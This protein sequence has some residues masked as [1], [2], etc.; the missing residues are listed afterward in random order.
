MGQSASSGGSPTEYATR[1]PLL[2][3]LRLRVKRTEQRRLGSTGDL[4]L[5][6]FRTQRRPLIQEFANHPRKIFKNGLEIRGTEA[7][8]DA[9]PNL[10][11]TKCCFELRNGQFA[12]RIQLT[13]EDRWR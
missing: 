1:L 2:R 3:P 10:L 4:P 8:N 7:M 11:T 12:L 5:L 9:I 6:I 13:D